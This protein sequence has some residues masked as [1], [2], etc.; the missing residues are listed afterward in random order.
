MKSLYILVCKT[1][2][3]KVTLE[4]L[5]LDFRSVSEPKDLRQLHE[6]VWFES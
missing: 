5:L 4:E 2:N 3:S 6:S 1:C